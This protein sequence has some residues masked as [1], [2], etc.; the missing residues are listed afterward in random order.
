[1]T[2]HHLQG[3]QEATPAFL[4]HHSVYQGAPGSTQGT[5]GNTK[6][7][8]LENKGELKPWAVLTRATSGVHIPHQHSPEEE[9]FSPGLGC[10][11]LQA[12]RGCSPSLK[13]QEHLCLACSHLWALY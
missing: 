5:A 10:L 6:A 8:V 1:M 12:H 4:G 7:L 2:N 11:S 13:E 9:A 3:V